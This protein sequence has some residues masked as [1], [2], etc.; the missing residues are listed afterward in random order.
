[1]GSF[2]STFD[3]KRVLSKSWSIL[4]TSLIIAMKPKDSASDLSNI[5]VLFHPVSGHSLFLDP[6]I[7]SPSS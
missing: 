5:P 4:L 3:I 6:I 2:C 1:M 7:I